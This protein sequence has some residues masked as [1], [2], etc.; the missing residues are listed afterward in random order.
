MNRGSQLAA[1]VLTAAT[2][3][4]LWG[5]PP[6]NQGRYQP[7]ATGAT[8][9]DANWPYWPVLMHIHPLTR[10]TIDR[11]SGSFLLEARAE[12][13]D[14]DGSSSRAFGQV[15]LELSDRSARDDSEALSKVWTVDLRDLNTNATHFDAVTRTYLFRLELSQDELPAQPELR[16]TYQSVD[17][18]T[19]SHRQNVRPYVMES[20]STSN[21]NNEASDSS[22]AIVPVDVDELTEFDDSP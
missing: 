7:I 21:N 6:G 15:L 18:A 13:Q 12:F 8:M 3:C 4:A 9:A 17:G 10:I 16:V 1:L 5:C 19:M 20:R 2:V 11:Q 22:P 14:V